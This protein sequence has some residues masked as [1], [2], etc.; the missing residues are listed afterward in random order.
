MNR[1]PPGLTMKDVLGIS[2][3]FT[4]REMLRDLVNGLG[5]E[6]TRHQ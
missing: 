2:K 1:L 5:I 3:T 6:V 4:A